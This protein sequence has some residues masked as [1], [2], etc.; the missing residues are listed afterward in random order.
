MAAMHHDLVLSG[1]DVTLR[2]VRPTDAAE[3]AALT[4]GS[5]SW[6]EELRWHTSTPPVDEPTAAESLA[7]MLDDPGLTGF[8][9]RGT[10]QGELRGIT[11]FYDHVPSVPRVEVGHTHYGRPFWGGVTNPAAKLLLLGHAF[12][13]WRC[14]RV[15]LRCDADNLRSVGAIRRLGAKPEG[16]LRGHRRRHDGTV[17]DTAYFSVTDAEWPVVREGLRA[18]VSP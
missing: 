18:R 6:P 3:Y 12:E 17:A 10:D 8:T 16:V 1:P 11:S 2:P 9:V 14:V 7:R 5:P 13:R 15:A 4:A